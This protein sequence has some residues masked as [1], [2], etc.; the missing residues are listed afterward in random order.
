MR[1]RKC[2]TGCSAAQRLAKA[3]ETEAKLRAESDGKDQVIADLRSQV[4]VITNAGKSTVDALKSRHTK[5]EAQLEES[6]Q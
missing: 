1:S 6:R 5:F 3:L 4:E 2:P